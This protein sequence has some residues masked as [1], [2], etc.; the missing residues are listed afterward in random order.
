ME[1]LGQ[2]LF[3]YTLKVANGQ[4]SVGELAGHSQVSIWRNWALTDDSKLAEYSKRPD[5]LSGKKI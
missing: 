2:R 3:E 4:K 1:T 5:L